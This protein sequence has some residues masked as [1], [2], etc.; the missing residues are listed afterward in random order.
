MASARLRDL[1]TLAMPHVLPSNLGVENERK[2][3][4]VW[5][6]LPPLKMFAYP[7]VHLTVPM[8]PMYD[9]RVIPA[10]SIHH[11]VI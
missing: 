7:L 11:I 6:F 2:M 1:A 5:E 8:L 4:S 10:L 9:C 3:G